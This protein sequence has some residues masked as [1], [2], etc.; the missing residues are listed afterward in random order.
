AKEA[1]KLKA[2]VIVMGS[3]GKTKGQEF[4][5]GSV[6]L[7]VIRTSQ[8]PI[9]IARMA[10][11]NGENRLSACPM[12]LEST[13]VCVD[14]E[15]TT[16]PVIKVA[17]DLCA[18][19]AKNMTLFHVIPSSKVKL[20]NDSV[21]QQR[22]A[23]LEELTKK[24]SKKD[25]WVDAHIHYGTYAY[26]IMEGAREINATL[27]VLGNHGKSLFHTMALGSTSDEVIR[28]SPIAVLIVPI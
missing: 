13:L 8:V 25:C 2:T 28:Q 12:L 23:E 1:K 7:G 22:K 5:I 26:N 20:T 14:L 9:L 27:I 3:S 6:S 19:G 17:E 18:V 24:V 4:F 11:K 16:Q 21:F 10:V 15:T